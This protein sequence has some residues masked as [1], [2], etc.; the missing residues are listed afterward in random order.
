MAKNYA[1]THVL[2][3]TWDFCLHYTH[4]V[5]VL[6]VT[7]EFCSMEPLTEIRGY[8]MKIGGSTER[9]EVLLR[10]KLTTPYGDTI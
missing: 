4:Y 9:L 5:S 10:S 6:P 8:Y 7:F 1:S 3:Y 2:L